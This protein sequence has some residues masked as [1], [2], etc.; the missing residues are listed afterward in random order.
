MFD[1]KIKVENGKV[2]VI[3]NIVEDQGAWKFEDSDPN[4]HIVFDKPIIALRITICLNEMFN[5]EIH[6]TVYFK[7]KDDAFSEDKSYHYNIYLNR[8]SIDDIYFSSPVEE[9]RFDIT[10]QNI[11]LAVKSII[12]NDLTNRPFDNILKKNLNASQFKEKILIVSHDLSHSGAPILAYNISKKML[13]NDIQVS[14]LVCNSSANQML[15]K[16]NELNIPVVFL[17]DKSKNKARRHFILVNADDEII[18]EDYITSIISAAYQLGYR[19]VIANTVIS[20]VYAKQFKLFDFLVI[21]LI[22]ETKV[23]IRLLDLEQNKDIAYYSDFIVFPDEIILKEFKDIYTDMNGR[24]IIRPQGIYLNS[25]LETSDTT[26][27]ELEEY[28]LCSSD[29]YIMGSGEANLRKGIDLFISAATILHQIDSSLHFIWTGNFTNSDLK[30]W[31]L[32]Q[33]EYTGMKDKI[34]IISFISN[35]KK[36]QTIL[37]NAKAFWLTSRSDTFPSVVLE[38]MNFNI[39]VIG[40]KNSGGINTMA[41]DNRG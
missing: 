3:N 34:H 25:I 12:F 31:L 21:T 18:Q 10:D 14:L 13:E 5:Q 32:H 16:Y 30:D 20:G 1:N 40:F 24:S 6:T 26:D 39:P 7:G 15:E 2:N 17:D 4:I 22:H 37:R 36:Y 8:T 41:C 33:I 27:S 35:Q 23:T 38:A 11:K 9:I 28:G 29:I 19:K